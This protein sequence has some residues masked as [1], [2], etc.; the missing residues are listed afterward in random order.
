M[1][2][3]DKFKQFKL[4]VTPET[5]KRIKILGVMHGVPMAQ[6]IMDGLDERLR[7]LEEQYGLPSPPIENTT[8]EEKVI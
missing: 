2:R 8:T 3:S 1:K 4:E 7:V 6:I 5:H